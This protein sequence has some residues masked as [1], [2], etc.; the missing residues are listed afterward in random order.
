MF[1]DV[2]QCIYVNGLNALPGFRFSSAMIVGGC[3]STIYFRYYQKRSHTEP[4]LVNEE[5]RVLSLLSPSN[6]LKDIGLNTAVKQLDNEKDDLPVEI[7]C[8]LDRLES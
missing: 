2:F 4:N 7:T 3:W 1:V 6:A 5:A 8:L